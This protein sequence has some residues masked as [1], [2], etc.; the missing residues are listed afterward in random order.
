MVMEKKL[1]EDIEQVAKLDKVPI[2]RAKSAEIMQNFV[3]D[4]NPKKILEIGTAIGYSGLLLLQSAINAELTTID[5]DEDRAYIAR[6]N[7]DRAGVLNRVKIIIGDA[8]EIVPC[9]TI[10]YD[11]I[12]LDGPKGKYLEMVPYLI[13]MLNVGGGIL[14]DNVLY[15]GL[16][17]REGKIWHKH[18]TIVRSLRG[19]IDLCMN[20]PRLEAELLRLEDGLIKGIKVSE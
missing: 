12:L 6:Q 18:R 15:F 11:F 3:R 5:I 20:D 17:E 10:K 13:D 14:I 19:T 1:L 16:V 9:H 8:S 2:I 7:F 4:I